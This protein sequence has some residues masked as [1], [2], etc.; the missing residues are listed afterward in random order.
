M[1]TTHKT[2]ALALTSLLA[3]DAAAQTTTHTL[4]G[5]SPGNFYGH[6]VA[7]LGDADLDGYDD[8]AVG[9]PGVD[10]NGA[11]SGRF[12]V[13]SGKTKAALSSH[14]GS[15]LGEQL[16]F[17]VAAA[18]D[19]DL[20]GRPDVLVGAPGALVGSWA[21]GKVFLRSGASGALLRTFVGEFHGDRFG[22]AV[23]G[24]GDVDL[25][26]VPDVAIGA[27][28]REV[29]SDW[30]QAWSVDAGLVTVFSGASGLVI[31]TFDGYH[32]YQCGWSLA[33]L[34]DTDSD[35][36]RELLLGS[37]GFWSDRGFVWR[38]TPRTGSYDMSWSGAGGDRFGASLASIG[39]ADGD[40]VDDFVV[41][42]PQ[43]GV[44]GSEDGYA[45]VHSGADGSTSWTTH[46][47]AGARLGASVAGL[48]DVDG[49]GRGD[50]AVGAPRTAIGL[51]GPYGAVHL[52]SGSIGSHLH[53]FQGTGSEGRFGTAI[54]A[55]DVNGD[56]TTDVLV[57]APFDP[58]AGTN[59]GIARVFLMGDAAGT[60]YCFGDGSASACPCAASPVGAR[61]GCPNSTGAAG[62]LVATGGASVTDDTVRLHGTGMTSAPC[63]YF[64]GT[65][66][67][68]G[69]DGAVFA[70]GLRCVAGTV[71]RLGTRTNLFG[72]S[73]FPST[74]G[75]SLS[76]L[77]LAQAGQTLHYQVWYRDTALL[78]CTGA[79]TNYTNGVS[80]AWQP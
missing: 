80:V 76:Q 60:A 18:G 66:Q 71:R 11:D 2:L 25:D 62:K 36:D 68:N 24:V 9:S 20:D 4:A 69:G 42:A 59:A 13:Y 55:G 26:G 56:G 61:A 6:A 30:D 37:P 45:T 70:D 22:H 3:A 27:P 44:G 8:F 14:A 77:G 16:G 15:A 21:V 46:G 40:G 79:M 41:G 52:K 54:S 39:D 38:V 31:S 33:A 49:D 35:G 47:G 67:V 5:T 65:A 17:A 43:D 53:T 74:S 58:T 1:N 7:C 51:L 57:G 29:W 12:Y 32:G 75:P 50:Y 48:G 10:A 23:A 63:L 72:G 64:Q 28:L 19:V 73:I 78:F 34:G